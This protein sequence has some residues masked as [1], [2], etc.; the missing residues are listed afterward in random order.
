MNQSGPS[1]NQFEVD[2]E[3][4]ILIM[5]GKDDVDAAGIDRYGES[6]FLRSSTREIVARHETEWQLKRRKLAI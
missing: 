3:D 2:P 4:D 5:V 6:L 1:L